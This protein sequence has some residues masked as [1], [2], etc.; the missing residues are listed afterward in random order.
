MALAAK[1]IS[2]VLVHMAIGFVVMFSLTGSIVFSGLAM[3]V[4]PVLNVLLLPLHQRSWA[5]VRARRDTSRALV[6]AGE[7]LS[8]TGLHMGVAF[9]VIYWATGSVA[10]GGAA[11]IIE[12]VCNVVLMPLHDRFWERCILARARPALAW[13]ERRRQVRRTEVVPAGIN[14]TSVSSASSPAARARCL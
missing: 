10:F 4:E 11:A 13:T 12:P 2:Q 5:A 9:V 7:K 6:I 3:L 8:Q 14:Q 1:K